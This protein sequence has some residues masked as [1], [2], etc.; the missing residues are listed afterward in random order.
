MRDKL[1]D[2]DQL[3]GRAVN[4]LYRVNANQHDP[5]V[6]PDEWEGE[7]LALIN[8]YRDLVLSLDDTPSPASGA[9]VPMPDDPR[10][11]EARSTGGVA[12]RWIVGEVLGANPS[13][14]ALYHTDAA[15]KYGIE[16]TVGV[17]GAVA[18]VIV[19]EGD[20]PEFASHIVHVAAHKLSDITP[21]PGIDV[22]ALGTAN[23]S[24]DLTDPD[25]TGTQP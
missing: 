14:H 16:V 23:V 21:P 3:M 6:R 4:L 10:Y 8:E 7:R 9:G 24:L 13:A 18:A 2:L 1:R 12:V 17:L 11:S 25:R 20:S 22:V 19:A 15:T 5:I